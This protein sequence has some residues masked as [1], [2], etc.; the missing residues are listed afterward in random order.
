MALI[1]KN[2]NEQIKVVDGQVLPAK[3]LVN[4]SNP[5]NTTYKLKIILRRQKSE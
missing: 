2:G 1:D 4:V 5:A 3:K